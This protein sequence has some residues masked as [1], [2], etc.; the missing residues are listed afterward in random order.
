MPVRTAQQDSRPERRRADKARVSH[1]LF[2]Q[3]LD[4]RARRLPRLAGAAAGDL[5]LRRSGAD[6]RPGSSTRPARSSRSR[7]R[8]RTKKA[9]WSTS[10]IDSRPALDR[11]ALPDLHHRRLLRPAAERR[12]RRLQQLPRQGLRP[13]QRPRGRRRPA[14]TPAPSATPTGPAITRLAHWAEPVQEQPRPPFRWVGYDGDAGHGCG[15]HLHLSWNHAAA[16]MFQLAEWV[17]VMARQ[18]HWREPGAEE[19][20][21]RAPPPAPPPDLPAGSPRYSTGGISARLAGD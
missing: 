13:L 11:Q 15:N 17:E 4:P 3:R 19:A 2:A 6:P 21:S 9:T 8:S 18:L 20:G 1:R 7:P 14:R 5:R 16:P 12:T 10:G